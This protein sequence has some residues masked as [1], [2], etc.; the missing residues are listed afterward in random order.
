QEKFKYLVD[1]CDVFSK[2]HDYVIGFGYRQR[3]SEVGPPPI[4][5]RIQRKSEFGECEFLRK[6]FSPANSPECAYVLRYIE[7][8]NRQD[9]LWSLRQYVVYSK[10]S[11]D[12][13]SSCATW[14]FLGAFKRA[15][16]ALE[17]N[18][19]RIHDWKKQN[20][21]EIHLMLVDVALKSWREYLIHLHDQTMDLVIFFIKTRFNADELQ[22]KHA[23]AAKD[24]QKLKGIEDRVLDAIL[25]LE[26]TTHTLM[27]LTTM[28]HRLYPS[29]QGPSD[30]RLEMIALALNDK[31][32][33]TKYT[34]K[35]A[36]AVLS[37]I[38]NTRALITV[39]LQLR[40]GND[41]NCQIEMLQNLEKQGQH[42]NA[43][44]RDLARKASQ[45][46][47][48]VK[49]LSVITL[50]WLP[51]TVVSSF[52]SSPFALQQEKDGVVKMEYSENCWIFWVLSISLVII[53]LAIWY[54]CA[55]YG[56]YLRMYLTLGVKQ[57]R[58]IERHVHIP[59]P[60]NEVC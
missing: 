36:E 8:T 46:S 2:F 32:E 60:K 22:S 45:E 53:S 12:P 27:A 11:T 29:K 54:I 37:K 48:S 6:I 17:D 20:P 51:F 39:I 21:F 52:Y 1:P 44:M 3:E 56:K 55:H 57:K 19:K 14:I 24:S 23:Q 9:N 43:A 10:Y 33:E 38:C 58:W 35:R 50:I 7:F 59:I 25:S 5:F 18:K 40:N 41:M 31:L 26:S 16:T 13:A 28:F 47:T 15:Q 42:E 30:E 4:S 34:Q 49:I